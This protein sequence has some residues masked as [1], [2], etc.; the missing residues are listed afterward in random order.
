M[1]NKL[2]LWWLKKEYRYHRRMMDRC[3]ELHY[4]AMQAGM[5]AEENFQINSYRYHNKEC[6]RIETMIYAMEGS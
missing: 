1:M 6:K 4:L 2:M 3:C 5:I